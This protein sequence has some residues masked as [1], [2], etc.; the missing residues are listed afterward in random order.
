MRW[1]SLGEFFGVAQ[2][3]KEIVEVYQVMGREAR[4]K[5]V[6]IGPERG[7]TGGDVRGGVIV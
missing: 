3:R 5:I 6:Q 2:V 4:E 1:K 7:W